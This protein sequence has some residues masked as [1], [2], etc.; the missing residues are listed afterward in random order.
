L[1][2]LEFSRFLPSWLYARKVRQA[3]NGEIASIVVANPGKSFSQLSTFMGIPVTY[4]HH[5]PTVVIPPGI[6]VVF[7]TCAGKLFITLAF[8]EGMMSPTE[9]D[10]FLQKIRSHLLHRD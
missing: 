6:G 9:A 4:Q 10:D 5:V 8:L 3:L 7:Y 2:A 1:C